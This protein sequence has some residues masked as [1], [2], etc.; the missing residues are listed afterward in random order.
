VGAEGEE[1]ATMSDLLHSVVLWR[2]AIFK[3]VSGVTKI[4]AMAF[5]GGTATMRLDPRIQIYLAAYVAMMTF[6]EGFIDTTSARLAAG[7]PPIGTNGTG[8]TETITK[9]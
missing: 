5:L 6:T 3:Y 7:K 2:L 4:G 9:P 1:A 8:N